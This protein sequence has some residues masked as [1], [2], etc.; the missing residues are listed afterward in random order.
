MFRNDQP[1]IQPINN[2]EYR[3]YVDFNFYFKAPFGIDPL[4]SIPIGRIDKKG[5]LLL[6]LPA[7]TK[8]NGDV[9]IHIPADEKT[10]GASVPWVLWSTGFSPMGDHLAG[11]GMHDMLYQYRVSKGIQVGI[12]NDQGFIEWVDLM[13]QGEADHRR[14]F[15]DKMFLMGMVEFQ[16]SWAKRTAFYNAVRRFGGKAY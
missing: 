16:S 5:D 14:L 1:V 10:D 12:F 9:R 6:A 11:S 15:A 3:Y 2:K 4:V 13:I 7:G 8:T